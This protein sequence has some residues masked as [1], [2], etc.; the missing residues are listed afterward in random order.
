MPDMLSKYA[1]RVI[2][3]GR[4]C[5]KST[6]II[7]EEEKHLPGLMRQYVEEYKMRGIIVDTTRDRE[8]P[9]DY[10]K[11]KLVPWQ[12][13]AKAKFTKGVVRTIVNPALDA[14]EAM[15]TFCKMSDVFVVIEEAALQIPLRLEKTAWE[16][17]IIES[18]NKHNSIA[19]M[20]HS[21]KWIPPR[22]LAILD[23]FVVFKSKID[24]PGDRGI[25]NRQVLE[26]YEQVMKHTDPYCHQ[27]VHNG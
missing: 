5:G 13:I 24:T 10:K 8:Y 25:Y 19:F 16:F 2:I 9:V 20:Y 7:G 27:I 18:K 6:F 22:M 17:F 15:W 4:N 11:V 23:E 12:D 3:G 26:A 1:V 14:E 21:W